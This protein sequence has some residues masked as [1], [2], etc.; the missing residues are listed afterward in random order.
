MPEIEFPKLTRPP[1]RE[2]LVDIRLREELPASVLSKFETPKGF[3]VRKPMKHGQFQLQAEP[4]KP[5]AAKVLT[6]EALGMRYERE[7]GSEVVQ[8]RRNG[9]TY[10]ILKDYPGWSV[11][12]ERAQSV[13]QSFL[14]ASGAVNVQRLAV[15]YINAVSIP[16]GA[17][18]DEYLT[19]APRI[20]KS[21]PQFVTGFMQRVL[22]PFAEDAATAIITQTF[23]PPT[24][25]VLDL[26]IFALCSLDGASGDIWMKLDRLRG[27]ADRIFFSSLTE[28]V[29]ES[30]K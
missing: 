20:P 19:T 8:F 27:I 2:A 24:N 29:I 12:R 13:W 9:M 23:E 6:E 22:V 30:Y 14:V 5:F 4:D 1:L 28:K 10:S 7:D 26:D 21:V 18:Y 11:F 16:F 17:D 25:A 3:P 15:R